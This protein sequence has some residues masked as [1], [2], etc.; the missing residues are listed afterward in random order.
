MWEKTRFYCGC[1]GE[2][3][4]ELE[5]KSGKTLFLACPHYKSENGSRSCPNRLSIDEA[6]G[7]VTDVTERIAELEESTFVPNIR[8]YR[9]KYKDRVDAAVTEYDRDSGSIGI[10]IVNSRAIR[11]SGGK[12]M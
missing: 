4:C 6:E 12:I 7:I 10:S 9:I 5:Y 11:S 8:G 3:K 2:E 1:H